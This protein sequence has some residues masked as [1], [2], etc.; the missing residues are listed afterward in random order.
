MAALLAVPLLYFGLTAAGVAELT[1]GLATGGALGLGVVLLAASVIAQQLR[2]LRADGA[3]VARTPAFV[4][5]SVEDLGPRAEAAFRAD[6]PAFTSA[7]LFAHARALA[8]HLAT[9]DLEAL[10]PFVS[11]GLFQRLKTQA[12][13]G[14]LPRELT[15]FAGLALK[16]LVVSEYSVGAQYQ[17]V[18]LRASLGEGPQAQTVTLTLLRRR[19]AQTRAAGLSAHQ[20]PQCGAPLAL[21][22]TQRCRFCEAI[23]NSGAH[24]WV[25]AGLLPGAHQL[26]RPADV[27]DPDALRQRDPGLAAEELV[28]RCTL[29]F[30]RWA[31]A[32][33]GAATRLTRVASPGFLGLLELEAPPE[34]TVSQGSCELRGLG[35]G[36]AFDEAQ[37]LVRWADTPASGLRS[38]QTIFRLRRPR[39]LRTEAALGLSAAR[40]TRCL[41]AHTDAEAPQ[42]DYCGAPVRD[43]WCLE[44]LEP[45][46]SWSEQAVA[47]RQQ[48]GGDWARVATPSQREA[49]LSLLLSVANADG[50]VAAAEQAWLEALAARWGVGAAQ[51]EVIRQA[52][53]RTV[54]TF[55]RELS[56]S[57][58]RELAQLSLVDGRVD[59][60]E[61]K[62]LEAIAAALGTEAELSRALAS[63]I[64]GRSQPG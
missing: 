56:R 64:A 28:D 20:C 39:G 37:L 25:L 52:P 31:E 16:A 2:A 59:P 60:K 42:C 9:G 5:P 14:G 43:A 27:L 6:D 46:A 21:S 53:A 47:V 15:A 19:V 58:T 32:R 44:A 49:A 48:L 40:C 38:H 63:L 62:R 29:I 41:A 17:H 12:R 55:A 22:A 13:L 36:E 18:G 35:S 54:P 57:L 61:R 3:V 24:D 26:A 10:R 23:V 45:F 34:G 30:W 4:P 33:R 51:L 11:D 7:G 50:A 8:G 1:V